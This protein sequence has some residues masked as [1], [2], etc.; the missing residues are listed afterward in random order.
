MRK[1]L[2]ACLLLFPSSSFASWGSS[3]GPSGP[4]GPPG[5]AGAS[6]PSGPMYQFS[7]SAQLELYDEFLWPTSSSSILGSLQWSCTSSGAASGCAN[8]ATLDNTSPGIVQNVTG[9]A[10]TGYGAIYL[11]TVGGADNF[12]YT[13][14]TS[15][16]ATSW[17][18]YLSALGTTAQEYSVMLGWDAGSAGNPIATTDGVLVRY[19]HA[20]GNGDVWELTTI[21]NSTAH[22]VAS[23]A[24]V[25]AT[26][27][28][29][30]GVTIA[31]S[32]ATLY[33]NGVS[34]ATSTTDL[35]R[36]TIALGAVAN[37][38]KS[39]GSTGV[40]CDVDYFHHIS[41]FSSAR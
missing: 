23:A 8:V 27:W 29:D 28:T 37:I 22:T 6:G 2:L 36:T 30:V 11:S 13:G 21:N 31:G 39:A 18:V 5:G 7:P 41:T 40:Y 38:L 16:F 9:T 12:A 17:R 26:T 35:P 20:D 33:V 19:A 1:L 24:A 10:T 3:A 14:N 4:S 25:S 15:S 32:T 34:V